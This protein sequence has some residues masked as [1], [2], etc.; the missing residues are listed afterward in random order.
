MMHAHRLCPWVDHQMFVDLW[1]N[2]SWCVLHDRNDGRLI[3]A[4]H[5]VYRLCSV[6]NPCSSV[7]QNGRLFSREC[8][9]VE[10]L[11]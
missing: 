7:R 10:Y 2:R 8:I 6:A 3:E 11:A 5:V 1:P 4:D 9:H